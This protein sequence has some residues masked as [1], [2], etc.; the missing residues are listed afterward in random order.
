MPGQRA[1]RRKRDEERRRRQE[2]RAAVEATAGPWEVLFSTQDP[3]EHRAFVRQLHEGGL[4][5]DVELACDML[6][7]RLVRPTWY[8]VRMRRLNDRPQDARGAQDV[9]GPQDAQ[10]PQG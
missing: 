9:R 2:R 4:P 6:C 3:A 5:E 8:Q 7:G 10:E 1:R